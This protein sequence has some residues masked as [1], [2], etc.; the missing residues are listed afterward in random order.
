MHI[1]GTTKGMYRLSTTVDKT[2]RE[3]LAGDLT[4][5]GVYRLSTTVD[6]TLRELL[7]GDLTT[8]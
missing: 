8:S 3:L 1:A 7:A 6:K 2:L 4:T 5:K